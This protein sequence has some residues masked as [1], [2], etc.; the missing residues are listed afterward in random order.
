MRKPLNM[1]TLHCSYASFPLPNV[2]YYLEAI[3]ITLP[4]PSV[5]LSLFENASSPHFKS[6]D[7]LTVKFLLFLTTIMG[8]SLSALYKQHVAC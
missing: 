5:K 8:G 4:C 3:V 1:L 2:C 6:L 7:K